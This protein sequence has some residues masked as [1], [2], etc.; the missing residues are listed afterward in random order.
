MVDALELAVMLHLAGNPSNGQAACEVTR[1]LIK[2]GRFDAARALFAQRLAS[3]PTDVQA[4][5]GHAEA[6]RGQGKLET[7]LESVESA[8]SVAPDSP[9]ALANKALLLRELQRPDEALFTVKHALALAPLNFDALTTQCFALLDAERPTEALDAF[10][11]LIAAQPCSALAYA[12]KATALNHLDRLP[13]AILALRAAQALEPD[14]SSLVWNES[15]A[16]LALGDYREGWRR[17]QARFTLPKWGDDQPKDHGPLWL[18]QTDLAGRTI[19]LH[20]EQGFG[21]TL[22]FCRYAPLVAAQGAQVLLQVPPELVCL[23]RSL[24]GRIEPLSTD[25]GGPVPSHDFYC[26]LMSL[27]LAFGTLVETIPARSPYLRADSVKAKQWRE[28]LARLPGLLVGLVW[29]GES[30]PNEAELNAV[31]QRR[32]VTL[33][34]LA[35]VLAEPDITFVSLQKGAATAQLVNLSPK[36]TIQ[37]WTGELEDF[38]DT[39]A[40][41]EGLDLVI[42]V[43]TSVA[44]LAGALAKPVWLLNRFDTCWRW[45]RGRTDSPWYPT[46]R[47]FRQPTRGDWNAAIADVVQA[48]RAEKENLCEHRTC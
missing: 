13:E 9:V 34:H 29:A 36:V 12:G 18:G 24:P 4:W 46:A 40:L 43:D 47:L 2:L 22:Q 37:D 14:D 15:L 5:L 38:A 23:M 1:L 39:A 6:L 32:S 19:L 26:P 27:P 30:Y 48:L 44:H 33:A 11:A 41:V 8:L 3:C 45:L 17:F 31:G 25:H 35:P 20:A 28:R 10:D 7:A 21:D 16:R 42:S